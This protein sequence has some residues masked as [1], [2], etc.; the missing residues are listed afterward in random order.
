MNDS[1]A[2]SK[3]K[4]HFHFNTSLTAINLAKVEH[5]FSIPKQTR[6]AFSMSDV[7]T[8]YHNILILDKFIEMFAVNPNKVKNKKDIRELVNFGKI[9]A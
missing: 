2:R 3:N 7:K 5:W 1:Q 8:L 4:L 9:A 6:G